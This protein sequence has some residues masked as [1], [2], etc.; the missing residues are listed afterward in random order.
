MSDGIYKVFWVKEQLGRHPGIRRGFFGESMGMHTTFY[1]AGGMHHEIG[2]VVLP[3]YEASTPAFKDIAEAWQIGYSAMPVA[4]IPANNISTRV[5]AIGYNPNRIITLDL[6]DYSTSLD[7]S[8]HL[9]RKT[10]LHSFITN[11]IA[12]KDNV[13]FGDDLNRLVGM[14]IVSLECFSDFKLVIFLISGDNNEEEKT[15]TVGK[16]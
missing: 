13:I 12:T 7:T 5:E 2:G 3:H 9:V 1:E 8:I 10:S 14:D 11:T 16:P 6:E 4:V 15:M